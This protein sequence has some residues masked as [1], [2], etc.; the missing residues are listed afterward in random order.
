MP[1]SSERKF[2]L[3]YEGSHDPYRNF[4]YE[5]EIG[6]LGVAGFSEVT[7]LEAEMET[8]EYQE[9]GLNTYVHKLPVRFSYPNLVLKRGLTNSLELWEWIQEGIKGNVQRMEVTV[10]LFDSMGK[11]SP[12]ETPPWKW[13]FE[14]AYPVKWTGPELQADQAAV[15]METL[16]L[17]HRG[18][19]NV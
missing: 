18:M 11:Q 15:S 19:S 13:G 10:Y 5:V 3:R 17:A 8:E 6:S 12:R 1:P 7:G 14:G 9:G 16:E 2:P 4:R